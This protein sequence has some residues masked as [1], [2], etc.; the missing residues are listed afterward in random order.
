MNTV[1]NPSNRI[2]PIL[3]AILIAV[4]LLLA[5]TVLLWLWMMNGGMMMGG[6]LNMMGSIPGQMNGPMIQACA[7]MMQN[8]SK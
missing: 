6:M 2:M 1:P 4:M 7:N 3:T 5:V 8:L